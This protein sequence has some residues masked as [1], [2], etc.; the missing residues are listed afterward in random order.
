MPVLQT[1]L[2]IHS[3]QFKANS[4]FMQALVDEF[5][6]YEQQV[7]ANSNS[8]RDRFA[9]RGQLLPR[10]RLSLLLDRGSPFIELCSL[11]GLH[12]HDDDGKKNAA[13]GGTIA[14]IGYVSGKRCMVIATDSAIKGGSVPPMGLQ[15][16]LRLQE[17]ARQQKL[18]LVTL[19]ESAGANL[20]Y[21]SELFNHGGRSFAN[22]AR[23]SAAGIPQITVVHGSSTAGGAYLPGL[24]DY[25]ILIRDKSKIFLAGPPLLKAATGEIASDEELGG[26]QM[27]IETAGT[28]EYIAEDDAHAI[29]TAR[30]VVSH[31]RWDDYSMDSEAEAPLYDAADLIGIVP[32]D[33]KKP[34]DCREIIMRLVDGSRFLGFKD[35]FGVS[36]VCGHAFIA[37]KEIG[38]IGNNGPIDA[39]GAVKAAQF[40]QLCCQ[41]DTPILF[42]MNTTGFLVGRDAEQAGIVKHGSKMIQAVANAHVPRV[43][44]VVGGS[45][46]AGNYGMCG[47]GFD[48]DFIFSW[49]SAKVGVMGPE[50]AATVMAIVT[51]D[52]FAKQGQDMPD[53]MAEEMKKSLLK[54]MAPETT[55]LF[56]TARLWD[57]GI[58]DPRDSRLVLSTAFSVAEEARNRPLKPNSFGVARG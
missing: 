27:H 17:I 46:G 21:Q 6:G 15:K 14:G 22:Q 50:Q 35:D 2:D 38:I 53:G 8:K 54:R 39:K 52:K 56:A 34:Y 45:W 43:T 5:R 49:P 7:R 58:I 24:S 42:L 47:R 1:S 28:A 44:L 29:E 4:A 13:G 48:P 31:L 55:A 11:A 30:E 33:S 40:I 37:G 25:T 57:D 36:T 16:G 12:M 23:L 41:S 26:A 51:E 3:D 20:L 32:E 18:P 9:K 19:A 10:D